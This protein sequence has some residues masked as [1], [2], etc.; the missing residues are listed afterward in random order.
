MTI[1]VS[2]CSETTLQRS[3][4][5]K[6]SRISKP[7]N[8]AITIRIEMGLTGPNATED[9]RSGPSSAIETNRITKMPR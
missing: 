3:L 6:R 4:L 8:Q 1:A 7:P 2:T 9:G 5:R